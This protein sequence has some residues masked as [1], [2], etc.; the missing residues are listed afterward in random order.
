MKAKKD[1]HN[2]FDNKPL[3]I[4]KPIVL[5]DSKMQSVVKENDEVIVKKLESLELKE[6]ND[7]AVVG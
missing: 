5:K 4:A 2:D 7:T 6:T 3:V 1:K